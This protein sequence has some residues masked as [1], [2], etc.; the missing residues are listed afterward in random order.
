MGEGD[1]MGERRELPILFTGEMV[2][3][4][5]D[6]RKTQTRRVVKL[7]PPYGDGLMPCP[8]GAP[9]DLLW[10]RE[11]W[12]PVVAHGCVMNTCDCGDV[13]VFY[14]ASDPN[15]QSEPRF[16]NDR[17]I[18]GE[19]CIPRAAKNGGWVPG[20]FMPRWA[21]RILLRVT[22]VRVERVQEISEEDAR[23]EGVEGIG[24]R[25]RWA[26]ERFRA[27]WDSVN[28]K[29]GYGWDVNPWVWVVGFEVEEVRGG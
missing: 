24:P 2:R 9:G 17:D 26:I 18:P 20:I 29:R 25:Q 13:N 7:R 28:A 15:R 6:G 23:A 5:L 1:V 14:R 19:W 12:H 21:S 22:D 16:F 27:L 10:V 3:A 11:A 4:I 8:Y